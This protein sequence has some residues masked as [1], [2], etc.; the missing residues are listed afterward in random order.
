MAPIQ[1][2]PSIPDGPSA[3]KILEIL[4]NSQNTILNQNIRIN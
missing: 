1:E 2:Y 3:K 4:N